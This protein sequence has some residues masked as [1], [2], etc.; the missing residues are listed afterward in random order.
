MIR[1]L[2]LRQ[3]SPLAV[4][5]WADGEIFGYI[6][7]SGGWFIANYWTDNGIERAGIYETA[8]AALEALENLR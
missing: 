2:E 4:E 8:A 3:A 5:T 7:A 6:Q 1:T